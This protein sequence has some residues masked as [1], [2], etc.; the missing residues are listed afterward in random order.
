MSQYAEHAAAEASDL[1]KIVEDQRQEIKS[2]KSTITDLVGHLYSL[3]ITSSGEV[4]FDSEL[5]G[6]LEELRRELRGH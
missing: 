4:T 3:S 6:E 2:L 5:V 1:K